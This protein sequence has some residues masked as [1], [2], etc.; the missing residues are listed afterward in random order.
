MKDSQFILYR[1]KRTGG[2]IPRGNS[3]LPYFWKLL[4]AP[5]QT[6]TIKD[7]PFAEVKTFHDLSSLLL[8]ASLNSVHTKLQVTLFR[9][10]LRAS[11]WRFG[12][13]C[14]TRPGC[15]KS[16]EGLKCLI[17]FVLFVFSFVIASFVSNFHII[18]P[19]MK[20]EENGRDES[21]QGLQ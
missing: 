7:W 15:S 16:S 10:L 3:A 21:K 4:L 14:L 17:P 12:L 2:N 19:D 13:F 1:M 9:D 6:P 20:L 5:V 11:I 8:A 18:R